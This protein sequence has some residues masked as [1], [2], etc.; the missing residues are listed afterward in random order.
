M[1]DALHVVCP[2]C[3]RVN[4]LPRE[5]LGAGG[6]CGGCHQ[7]LFEGRPAE[8]GG[9]RLDRHVQRTDLPLLVD[10]WA[11]WCGPCKM[12]A[13]VLEQAAAELEPQVQVAKLNTEQEPATASRF[14]IRGIPTLILFRGGR[15][16]DR[17]SGALDLA[18][19]LEWVRARL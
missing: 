9:A 4:R 13:P 11:P 12:M 1:A 16:I 18:A 17:L 19:L 15:E 5:K 3:D 7:A 8:L 14:A 10:F 2:H 6:R